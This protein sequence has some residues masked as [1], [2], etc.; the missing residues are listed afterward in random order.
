MASQFE[1]D[2]TDQFIVGLDISGSMQTKDC[3]GDTTRFSYVMEQ[4]KVFIAEAAKWDPD[5]VSFYVFNNTLQTYPD[6]ASVATINDVIA[7]LRPSGGTNTH[8]AITA[9]Y[10]EHKKKGSEQTF[11]MLFTDGEPSDP[12][13]VKKAIIDITQD[14]KDEKEFRIS[15]LTVG[16]RTQALDAWLSALDND[17]TGAKYD[18]IDIERLENVDFETAVANAI[19]GSHPA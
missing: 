6:V 18:I 10:A 5:G 15:M 4:M 17:L 3:P 7:K 9:A 8:L 11:F 13:A 19:E 12:E 2:K 14:V 1:L 16:T